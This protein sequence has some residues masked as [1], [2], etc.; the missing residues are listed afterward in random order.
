MSGETDDTAQRVAETLRSTPGP[1][2]VYASRTRRFELYLQGKRVETVR[3]PVEA[4]GYALRVFRSEGATTGV[5]SHSSTDLSSEGIRATRATAEGLLPHS[6][7]PATHIPLPSEKLHGEAGLEIV[8]RALWDRPDER[9]EEYGEAL[10]AAFAPERDVVPTFGAIR[11]VLEEVSLANSAGADARFRAT[12]VDLET[13]V[14]ASGGT[15]GKPPGEYWTSGH[16]RRLD[17]KSV[18]AQVEG[19][20][21][22]ARAVRDARPSPTGQFPV[23]LP[24]DVLD[25]VLPTVAL[26]RLSGAARL[27]K[28]AP[29]IGSGVAHPS[30]SLYDDG[31]APWSAATRPIDGEG[32]RQ[33]RTPLIEGG[34]LT[35]LLYDALHAGAFDGNPTGNGVRGLFPFPDSLGFRAPPVVGPTTLSFGSGRGGTD[36]ELIEAV[37]DGLW[38][39]E[40][41]FPRPDPFTTAFGGEVRVGYRIR[42]GKLREPVRGGTVGGVVLAPPGSPSLLANLETLGSKATV[43]GFVHSAP[44]LVRTLAVAGDG[45]P[46]AA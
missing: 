20:S 14:K 18:R 31:L 7:F 26:T 34:K 3:G 45:A 5:G 36:E 10:L 16:T 33:R 19:W 40:I 43:A 11:A 28:I 6:R 13:I 23:I 42:G 8:D 44:I 41:G 4:T 32:S 29:E 37:G 17:P 27:Q 21:R 1:W 30:V 25:A 15:E 46:G 22:H 24:V 9:I 2:E 38:V 39:Q 12:S 35:G